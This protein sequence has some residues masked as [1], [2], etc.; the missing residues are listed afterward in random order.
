MSLE[1][2]LQIPANPESL[3][4]FLQQNS[5]ASSSLE[6]QLM[7]GNVKYDR[8]FDY[9]KT[10]IQRTHSATSEPAGTVFSAGTPGAMSLDEVESEINLGLWKLR[11]GEALIHLEVQENLSD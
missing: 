5:Q 6:K 3:S 1:R 7:M 2:I 11:L 8:A 9:V 4:E 10:P